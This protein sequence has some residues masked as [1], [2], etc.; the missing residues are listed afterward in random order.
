MQNPLAAESQIRPSCRPCPS[1]QPRNGT[2]CEKPHSGKPCFY[3]APFCDHLSRRVRCAV[4]TAHRRPCNGWP[5]LLN[6][7]WRF[8]ILRYTRGA[9][10]QIAAKLLSRFAPETRL[11]RK[12]PFARTG[13]HALPSDVRPGPRSDRFISRGEYR[14]LLSD[15]LLCSAPPEARGC[16]PPVPPAGRDCLTAAAGNHCLAASPLASRP[17]NPTCG[18]LP[19]IRV[20]ST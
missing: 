16:G 12:P 17:T 9:S 18:T 8:R 2:T 5:H 19:H 1:V 20:S 4:F 3:Y 6:L 15:P 7:H 14:S 11:K 13:Q 10:R